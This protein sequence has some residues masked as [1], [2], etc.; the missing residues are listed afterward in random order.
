[1]GGLPWM[2][3]FPLLFTPFSLPKAKHGETTKR[4]TTPN[5]RSHSEQF[6]QRVLQ[7]LS[8][9]LP[10]QRLFSRKQIVFISQPP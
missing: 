4:R 10:D 2:S 5:F 3:A 8:N 7:R 6:M 9:L 1:M